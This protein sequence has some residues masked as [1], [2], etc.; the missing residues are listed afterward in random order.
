MT[1]ACPACGQPGR[2]RVP[3]RSTPIVPGSFQCVYTDCA[4]LSYLP[5]NREVAAD[6]L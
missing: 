5:R 6:E 3:S 4:V 2:K 1:D